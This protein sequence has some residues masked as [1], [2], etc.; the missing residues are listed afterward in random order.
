MAELEIIALDEAG[1]ELEAPQA[2]DTYVAKRDVSIEANIS[3]TGNIT[4]TGLVDG[5]DVA[6]DGALAASATQPGDNISTL[7]NDSGFEANAALASQAEAEAGVENTKTMTALRVAQ[8]I[9]ILAAGIKNNYGSSLDPT[10][11][12]DDTEGYSAGSYWIN[13]ASNEVFRCVDPTTNLAVWIKT[14]LSTDELATVAVSGDS[15]DLTEGSVNLLLTV[16][17]RDA[18]ATLNSVTTGITAYAGGGQANATELSTG[19]NVIATVATAWD[20]IKLPTAVTGIKVSLYNSGAEYAD[21][22]PGTGDEL[23]HFAANV[24]VPISPNGTI[25]LQAINATNWILV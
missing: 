15:D 19:T 24:A 2:G 22:Y 25:T 5:R 14:T 11:T 20:S 13:T 1:N 12:N 7:T 17:E 21:L 8:A 10:T 6:A 9:A 4:V 18:I 16:L 3:T 23:M